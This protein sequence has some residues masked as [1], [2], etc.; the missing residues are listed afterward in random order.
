MPEQTHEKVA[1]TITDKHSKLKN[2]VANLVVTFVNKNDQAK[3]VEAERCLS[4]SQTLL[5]LLAQPDKPA[6]LK[7]LNGALE[8]YTNNAIKPEALMR[9]II[10]VNKQLEA[11]QFTHEDNTTSGIDFEETFQQYF[12]ESRLPDLF[13]EIINL[14]GQIRDSGEIDSKSMLAALEELVAS[15]KAGK[16][17]SW[18][19]IYGS[20]EFLGEFIRTYAYELAIDT[21]LFGKVYKSFVE[22]SRK[23][24]NEFETLNDKTQKQ[25]SGQISKSL[26]RPKHTH[27][28]D[29][30]LD[31][32]EILNNRFK[33][34]S[35]DYYDTKQSPFTSVQPGLPNHTD[36]PSKD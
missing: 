25:Y 14:L 19:S 32:K 11:Y 2:N 12:D 33:V 1:R 36:K 28:R 10:E 3:K 22:V 16:S 31:Y 4:S 20:R 7:N 34:N 23:F 18:L 24:N 6:W 9:T 17:G 15:L 29:V 26:A 27:R 21:P 13:D 30:E 35:I 5:D 8:R